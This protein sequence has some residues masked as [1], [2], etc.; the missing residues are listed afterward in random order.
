MGLFSSKKKV[1]VDTSVSRVIEDNLLPD[2][3]KQGVISALFSNDG[4]MVEHI[5]ESSI[6]SIGV[7]AERMYQFGKR[8]YLYGVP[9]STLFYSAS[10]QAVAQ[11]VLSELVGQDITIEYYQY[12]VLNNLH[13]GWLTLVNNY[14]YD[15]ARNELKNLSTLK[16][17]T[18]YLTDLQVVV[19]EATVAELENGSLAQWGTPATS[20]YTPLR[21][22]QPSN[23]AAWLLR[24]P[25]PFAVDSAAPGDYFRLSYVWQTGT[26]TQKVTHTEAL[27][28][29]M[30]TEDP[31]LDYFQV[32][33]SY[34]IPGQTLRTI[35]YW[36]Y[37]AGTG[38]Y[39][40]LDAVFTSEYDDLGSFFPIGYFRYNKT[41]T[42]TD[43]ASTEYRHSKKLMK[44]LGMD[45]AD[46]RDAIN[47]NPDIDDVESA[48]VMMAVPAST[49]NPMERRYLFDFFKSIYLKT[50][51]LDL[52]DSQLRGDV[53]AMLT[54]V[55]SPQLSLVIQDA[56][57]KMAVQMSGLYR[58]YRVGV[59][60][61]K[62]S[63]DSGYAPRTITHSGVRYVDEFDLVGDPYTHEFTI[64]CYYYRHQVSETMYEELEVYTLSALYYV[65]GKY[66][67]AAF[68]EEATLLIP[69]D[70]SISEQY[71]A[72]DREELYA[73]SLHYLFNTKI[74]TKVKWY[75]QAWFK[76]VL[77]VVAVVISILS[78]NPGPLMAAVAAGG[79][80]LAQFIAITILEGL[81]F[82]VAFK[83]FVKVVGEKFAMLVAVL[84]ACYSLGSGMMSEGGL[85]GVPWGEELLQLSSGISKAVNDSIQND[86]AGLQK[87]ALEFQSFIQEQSEILEKAN[88]LLDNQNL[89]S[90][91]VLFGESPTDYYERTV[92]SGN[93]GVLGLDA[94][95]SYC[96]IALTLPKLSQTVGDSF[97]T[98]AFAFN[99]LG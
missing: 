70:H 4:Q 79:M 30:S 22:A 36:T 56:R 97:N 65:S 69:L 99:N 19:A 76:L 28:F 71:S 63:Y 38:T 6:N 12:G 7:K 5:L 25:T 48:L 23:L 29:P 24:K 77:I 18:V 16:G 83:L 49:T 72:S 2:S 67:D 32:K 85:K 87:D 27:Q 60:G 96:D 89:L 1:T 57:F 15:Q 90:P 64:P 88:D 95:T 86:L 73:R 80:V 84:A 50:G 47:A 39:P 11:S 9:Q 21:P 59:V 44:Y 17:A 26:G 35:K 61:A 46:V 62:G 54:G 75:Q 31:N 13:Y 41:A 91:F 68:E 43:P 92:H 55:N 33:Y 8:D 81:L 98:E 20:G 82:S 40:A 10:G 14:G 93:I 3:P 51:E 34:L 58:H 74:V 45:Y 53:A 37:H 52:P 66:A 42:S 94:V 78:F